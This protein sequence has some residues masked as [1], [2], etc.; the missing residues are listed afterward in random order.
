M[1]ILGFA[2][3]CHLN[4]ARNIQEKPEIYTTTKT[5]RKSVRLS[6]KIARNSISLSPKKGS[7]NPL[8]SSSS[9]LKKWKITQNTKPL[10]EMT[11]AELLQ[12][13]EKVLAL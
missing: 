7:K 9:S 11:A 3:Q 5:N 6:M 4:I 8:S 12:E 10:L 1:K 13:L 2:N